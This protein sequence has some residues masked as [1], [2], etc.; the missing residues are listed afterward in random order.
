MHGIDALE[1]SPSLPARRLKSLLP[2]YHAR[3]S[4]K[5]LI[6]H[7]RTTIQTRPLLQLRL[8]VELSSAERDLINKYGL[9]PFDDAC[10]A[11]AL[12][13]HTLVTQGLT[14]DVREVRDVRQLQVIE[15]SLRQG[16]ADLGRYLAESRDWSGSDIVE[17]QIPAHQP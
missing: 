12:D 10:K 9:G 13:S 6:E 5:L 15:A 1:A 14:T 2:R 16:F 8:E 7:T 11:H 4:M 3:K 17:A